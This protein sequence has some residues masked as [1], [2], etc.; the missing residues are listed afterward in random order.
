MDFV[1]RMNQVTDKELLDAII[2]MLQEKFEDFRED[3][4]RC[5]AAVTILSGELGGETTPSIHDELDAIHR[6]AAS[7]LLFSGFLGFMANLDHYIN[8]VA[9]TFLDVD[10]EVFLREATAKKLPD[11]EKAQA[12]RSQFYS[13]LTPEQREVYEDIAIYALHLESV[14]PKL[15]HYYGYLLGNTLL[16]RIVPGYYPDFKLAA[17]YKRQIEEFMGY[18]VIG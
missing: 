5:D 7:N 9:R 11:Y 13:L 2:T 10:A 15:G 6:Q 1:L 4:H 18:P 17:H 16:P 3:R 12:V 14:I 8:P